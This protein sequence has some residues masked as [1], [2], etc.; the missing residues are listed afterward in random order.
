MNLIVGATGMLGGEICRLLVER[1]KK[2]RALVRRTSDPG[3]VAALGRVGAEVVYGDFA[4]PAQHLKSV[5]AHL[6]ETA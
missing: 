5:R 4:F 1:G 2:V 6:S 3:K